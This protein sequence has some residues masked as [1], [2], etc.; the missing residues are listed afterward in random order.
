MNN[1]TTI[2]NM[3][4]K[5]VESA[6][7]TIEGTFNAEEN[8]WRWRKGSAEIEV[9][10]TDGGNDRFYLVVISA[11]MEVPSDQEHEFYRHLLELNRNKLGVK[12][13]I[14]PETNWVCAINERD[15]EGIDYNELATCISDLEWWADELDD[16]LKAEFGEDE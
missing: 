6:G 15:V 16:E 1:V 10:I 2:H 7:L 9:Y 13:G 3:I 12:F 8:I 11:I 5:Y 14:V 4:Q